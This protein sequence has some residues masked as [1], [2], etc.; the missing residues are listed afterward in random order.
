MDKKLHSKIIKAIAKTPMLSPC[1]SRLLEVCAAPDHSL[2]E[3]INI[4]RGDFTL[5]AQI[6]RISNSVVFNPIQPIASIDR[7]V[8]YLGEIYVVG[9]A[10]NQGAAGIFNSPLDGYEGKKRDLWRHQLY[11]AIVARIIS[12]FSRKPIATDLAFTGGLLHDIGKAIL[13]E[14]IQ[15]S[16]GE[17]ITG[18]ASERYQDY[19]DAEEQLFGTDHV[20][21]GL[22]LAEHWRLPQILQEIIRHHHNPAEA[23][24]E[25][26]ALAYAV[27]FGDALSMMAGYDTGSDGLKYH[28]DNGYRDYFDLA[29]NKLEALQIEAGSEFERFEKSID[30]G[31]GN[32]KNTN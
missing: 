22:V 30:P 7:A 20:E 11:C 28:L 13:S 31:S 14:H 32:H 1:I 23:Q 26:R 3:I 29:G 18:I 9:I 6:L 12:R 2:T 21:V 25:Y 15:Q 10:L 19:K 16:A 5:T 17:I 8:S 24:P 27:H 4:I